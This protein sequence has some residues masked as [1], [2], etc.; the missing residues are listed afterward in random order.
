MS[1]LNTLAQNWGLDLDSDATYRDLIFDGVNPGICMNDNC[2]YSTE[3]EPD[4]DAGY[5]E[6]C[7]TNTVTSA[8]LL[9]GII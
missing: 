9:L 6:V 5:C 8:S 7:G 3:V 1:K 4:Q 2:D